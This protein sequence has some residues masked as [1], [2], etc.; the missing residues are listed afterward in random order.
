MFCKEV[1]VY[2]VEAYKLIPEIH[3]SITANMQ[4]SCKRTLVGHV[5]VLVV[6]WLEFTRSFI[7]TFFFHAVGRPLVYIFIFGLHPGLKL[8]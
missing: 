5:T 7:W 8:N 6:R 2:I 3:I 4:I 1:Q